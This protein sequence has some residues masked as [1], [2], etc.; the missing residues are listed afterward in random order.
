MKRIT[1]LITVIL[2]FALAATA[3]VNIHI[4]I[5]GDKTYDSVFVKSEA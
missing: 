5:K 4:D 1:C 3:Q 2:L